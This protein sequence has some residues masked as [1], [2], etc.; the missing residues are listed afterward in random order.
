M[1]ARMTIAILATAIVV[2]VP[3]GGVLIR[4]H[5]ELV[6]RRYDS[7]LRR[8][9][10]VYEMG[11]A[12]VAVWQLENEHGDFA[13]Q[14]ADRFVDYYHWPAMYAICMP[15]VQYELE[16]PVMCWTMKQELG[17][18]LPLARTIRD[19]LVRRWRT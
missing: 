3:T 10:C 6:Q 15:G 5:D 11:R 14:A 2:G 13:R 9:F 4:Q 12:S 17:C 8:E 1:H 16:Q 7:Q 19:E 18:V